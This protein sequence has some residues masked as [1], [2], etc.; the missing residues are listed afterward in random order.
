[1]ADLVAEQTTTAPAG[2]LTAGRRQRFA[3]KL[4]LV[5]VLLAW[6]WWC[7]HW[8][9]L[10]TANEAMRLLF[11]Q[12]VA[13]TGR[14]E[15]ED[16]AARYGHVPVD[17]SSYNGHVYM[18]KA[19][20]A[21]LLALPIYLIL[22]PIMPSIARDDQWKFGYVATLW[23]MAVPLLVALALLQRALLRH[24]LGRAA[25]GWTIAALATASPLL[26]YASLFFGHAL[27]AAGVLGAFALVAASDPL[28]GM[29]RRSA[30]AA[31]LMLG[32]AGLSDTPVFVLAGLVAV[33]SGVRA[34]AWNAM[35]AKWRDL[36]VG[37][38]LARTWPVWAGLGAGAVAQLGY[39]WWVLD[40]PLRF[41]YQFKADAHLAAIMQTGWLGFR[42]PQAEA[43]VGLLLSAKR[44]LLYHAPWLAAAVAGLAW[45]ARSTHWSQALRL[46]AAGAL[47]MAGLYTLFVSGFA[48]WPAGDSP[49]ARHLLP[50]VG[51]C[52]WGL[53]PLLHERRLP[54]ALRATVAAG[55]LAGV[56][57]HLPI[58]AT[59]PYHFDKLDRPVLDMGVPLLL[60][61][62]FCQS[63]GGWLGASNYWS[64]LI[65][66]AVVLAIWILALWPGDL[67]QLVQGRR[68]RW[69]I[70]AVAVVVWATG[71]AASV[72]EPPG[73][74]AE[75]AR[76]KGWS[77]LKSGANGKPPGVHGRLGPRPPG[78]KE[79]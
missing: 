1:M 36:Q 15:L 55:C 75:I 12:A 63:I 62:G 10:R 51:L 64:L 22:R 9:Y 2:H 25:V 52:G 5:L 77:M 47:G 58:A 38:R 29:R 79:L 74:I 69:G 45:V 39:N 50:V 4:L 13:E 43:L 42:L 35:P 60:R 21:S 76:Y 3:N 20:G 73:R 44:G 8:P 67:P 48:D 59:F 40:H 14:P 78:P 30:W 27:A 56:V 32:W 7:H 17:R 53:A 68:R 72:P 65:F 46:D 26:V 54:G 33:F 31:G 70:A 71:M 18:D 66:A 19:P 16:V 23:T 49:C 57:M 6:S 61:D 24:G 41:T 11:V 28:T 37:E 34:A